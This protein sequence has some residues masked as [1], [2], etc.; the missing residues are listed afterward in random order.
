MIPS[1][2]VVL[3]KAGQSGAGKDIAPYSTL[4][5]TL[6]LKGIEPTEAGKLEAVKRAKEASVTKTSPVKKVA[7]K[8]VKK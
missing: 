5:F 3:S 7:K 1:M 2:L 6:E 4:I 8:T